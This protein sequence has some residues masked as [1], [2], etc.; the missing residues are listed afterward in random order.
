M[1]ARAR[2]SGFTLIEI[3]A[4]FSILA[5]GLALNMSVASGSMQQARRSATFWRRPGGSPG[6]HR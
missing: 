3:V 5:I 4:A 2:Q 1:N 6:W